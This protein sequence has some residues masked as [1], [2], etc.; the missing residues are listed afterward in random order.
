MSLPCE[1]LPYEDRLP[2]VR[3]FSLEKRGPRGNHIEAF[4]YKGLI[5]KREKDFLYEQVMIGEE[6]I[7][8]N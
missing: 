2:E 1:L 7:A 8:W 3:F 4:Q 5:K 6:A